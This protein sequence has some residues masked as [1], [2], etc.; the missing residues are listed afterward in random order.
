MSQL[1]IYEQIRNLKSM[2][3]DNRRISNARETELEKHIASLETRMDGIQLSVE[4]SAR[5]LQHIDKMYA[6]KFGVPAF[7][8]EQEPTSN[9]P[10]VKEYS[11]RDLDKLMVSKYGKSIKRE[12]YLFP[13]LH[14]E[15]IGISI[16]QKD[17]SRLYYQLIRGVNAGWL[18]KADGTSVKVTQKGL[19]GI[20]SYLESKGWTEE[21]EE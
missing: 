3:L 14:N 16:K 7:L 20:I 5:Y 1:T 18:S 6:D 8:E 21:E 2:I 19:E 9:E 4:V 13:L 11:I 12:D 17:K 15:Y 10:L